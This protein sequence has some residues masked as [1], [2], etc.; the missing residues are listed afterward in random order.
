MKTDIEKWYEFGEENGFRNKLEFPESNQDVVTLTWE[1]GHG[2]L[3][4]YGYFFLM[5]TFDLEGK[6]LGAGIWE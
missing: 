4:G 6:K 3:Q 5:G 2:T 1:A